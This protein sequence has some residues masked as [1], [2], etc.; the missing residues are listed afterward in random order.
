M[1]KRCGFLS[2]FP[3]FSFT[4]TLRGCVSLKKQKS[5]GK[6]VEMTVNNKEDNSKDFCL[7]FVQEFG[8]YSFLELAYTL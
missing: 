7:D 5:Q 6:A 2:G 3:P 1:G 8:L 4:E